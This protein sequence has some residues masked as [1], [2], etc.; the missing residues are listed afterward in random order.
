M[1]PT[2]LFFVTFKHFSVFLGFYAPHASMRKTEQR[3]LQ[4]QN[5]YELLLINVCYMDLSVKPLF[6]AYISVVH[7]SKHDNLPIHV[8]RP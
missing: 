3:N 4:K 2:R 5:A 7:K 8:C 6:M 1:L